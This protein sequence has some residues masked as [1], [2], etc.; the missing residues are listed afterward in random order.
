MG[1][2]NP[3][4]SELFSRVSAAGDRIRNL[5]RE[6]EDVFW[7]ALAKSLPECQSGDFPPDAAA[8]FQKACETAAEAWFGANKPKPKLW[9]FEGREDEFVAALPITN[10]WEAAWEHPGFLCWRWAQG[11]H[12]YEIHATPDWDSDPADGGE[13]VL[14]VERVTGDDGQIDSAVI[15]WPFVGRTVESYRDLI[16][17]WLDKYAPLREAKCELRVTMRPPAAGEIGYYVRARDASA[18]LDEVIAETRKEGEVGWIAQDDIPA[19]PDDDGLIPV[20][21]TVGWLS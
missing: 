9:A 1:D 8:A 16:A 11:G 2:K 6:A 17:P 21:I 5:A 18:A 19:G 7:E 12:R 3:T 4:P 13:I 10:G 15:P 20:T 14:S